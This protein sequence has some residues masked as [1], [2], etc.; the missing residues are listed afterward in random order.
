ME[1]YTWI[2]TLESLMFIAI[3]GMFTHFLKKK[4]K[5]ETLTEIKDYFSNNLKSTFIAFVATMI[6]TVVAY[7]TMAS[8][9]PIDIAAFFGIGYTFDSFFNKWE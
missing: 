4:I 3:L 6:A 7:F 9:Q 8:K 5:G 2:F 1:N